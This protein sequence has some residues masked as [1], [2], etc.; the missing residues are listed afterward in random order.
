MYLLS[1]I[2]IFIIVI[3]YP[4]NSWSAVS[5]KNS[6]IKSSTPNKE[7]C[8]IEGKIENR[9]LYEALR[10]SGVSPSEI[11]SLSRDFKPVFDFRCSQ[12]KDYY[13]AHLNEDKQIHKFRYVTGPMDEYEAVKESDG[14]YIVHKKQVVLEREIKKK[15]FTIET[16]LYQA[17]LDGGESQIMAG[18]IVEIFAWDIDF[19]L[20]PRKGDK[21]AVVY[22][23][24]N[25]NGDFVQYGDIL[26]ACYMGKNKTYSAFLYNNGRFN[27]YYDEEG[28]PVKKMFLRIPVKFG[29]MTSS[30]SV[31]R[32]HPVSHKY[33][34][35]TGID[36]GAK[37]GTPI[38]AT[39]SG[40]V[41]FAGWR[42][43]YGKLVIIRHPNGYRTYYGHCSKILVKKGQIVE[44]EQL[45]AKV[46]NT[47]I[48]TGPHVHY[49]VRVNGVPI[50]PN[51]VKK[52]KG[53]PLKPE[54][55][56]AFRETVRERMLII[57][58]AL[59]ENQ[60][61]QLMVLNDG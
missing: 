61:K 31:R 35:H 58:N 59:L 50:N 45:I 37:H 28:D 53:E 54:L 18:L 1:R 7:S 26:A 12:P 42:S 52:S 21:I 56:A 24:C 40:Q 9:T 5:S 3:I 36:Y 33:K 44:Q 27:E 57:E 49:E 23:R 19:Y 47:G 46:G 13:Q 38:F 4:L 20:Y 43:S 34:R 29:K 51:K 32:F 22:E 8:I 16:S 55:M 41:T 17:V 2:T 48:A 15:V 10:S 25:K 30:Y 11:L 14:H 6:E 60:K 39:A